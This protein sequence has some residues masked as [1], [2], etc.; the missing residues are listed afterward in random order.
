MM[1]VEFADLL[2]ESGVNLVVRREIHP[3]IAHQLTV[4]SAKPS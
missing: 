4:Q 3:A 2:Q 1:I